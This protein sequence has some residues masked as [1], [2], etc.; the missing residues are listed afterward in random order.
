MIMHDSFQMINDVDHIMVEK[1]EVFNKLTSFIKKSPS[2]SAGILLDASK[3]L[4]INFRGKICLIKG[5]IF[6][7]Y[8]LEFSFIVRITEQMES[9]NHDYFILVYFIRLEQNYCQLFD[10]INNQIV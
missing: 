1:N 9:L 8:H 3:L 2:S 4:T 10:F 5:I 7:L 6:W